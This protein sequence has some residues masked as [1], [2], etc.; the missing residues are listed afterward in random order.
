MKG[1]EL[2]RKLLPG[3][4]LGLLGAIAFVTMP[5]AFAVL[6]RISAGAL[7]RQVFAVEA[8]VSLAFGALLLIVERRFALERHHATGSSQFS[9]DMMLSLGALSC[10]VVGYYGLLPMMET[11]R[12]GGTAALGFGQLHA[13]G[14]A[15]FGAKGLLVLALAWRAAR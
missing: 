15:F 3:V 8:P 2:L 1:G 9:A 11:A 10:T 6:D 5:A 7:A 13:L 4:W 14:T 12:A